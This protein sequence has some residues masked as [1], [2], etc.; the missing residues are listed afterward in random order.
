MLPY[1]NSFSAKGEDT[2][3]ASN[4]LK[5]LE[6]VYVSHNFRTE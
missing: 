2:F 5:S 4:D 3:L 6:P 1:R